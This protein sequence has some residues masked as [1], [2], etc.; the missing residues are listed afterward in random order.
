MHSTADFLL[1]CHVEKGMYDNKQM[2]DSIWAYSETVSKCLST[3][4]NAVC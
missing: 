3:E 1:K 2:C 4:P